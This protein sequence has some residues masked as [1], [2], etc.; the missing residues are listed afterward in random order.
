[1]EGKLETFYKYL[2][3][4]LMPEITGVNPATVGAEVTLPAV[5]QRGRWVWDMVISDTAFGKTAFIPLNP[6]GYRFD[7]LGILDDG[8]LLIGEVKNMEGL[9][10]SCGFRAR[11]VGR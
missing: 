2:S 5:Y 4:A 1:M 3:T 8:R 7:I 6:T 11:Q 10:G 9:G